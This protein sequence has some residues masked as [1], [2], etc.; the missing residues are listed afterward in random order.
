M[1]SLQ[2]AFTITE[3]ESILDR[4]TY[5]KAMRLVNAGAVMVENYEG[6]RLEGAVI[7][8]GKR[9]HPEVYMDE[10]DDIFTKCDCH[11]SAYGEICVH[12]AALLITWSV[13]T[14]LPT[15]S[16]V[17]AYQTFYKHKYPPSIINT[18]SLEE[19]ARDLQAY[20]SMLTVKELRAL[21]KERNVK[22]SGLKREVILDQLVSG[23]TEPG[24]LDLALQRLPFDSR[25][26]FSYVCILAESLNFNIHP[27]LVSSRFDALLAMHS[28]GQTVRTAALCLEDL[29]QAGLLFGNQHL[30]QV[31]LQVVA[32]PE[33]QP[34][35]FKSTQ[36]TGVQKKQTVPFSAARLGLFLLVL[37]RSEKLKCAPDVQRDNLGWPV[38]LGGRQT[39]G[40]L[41]VLSENV[42]FQKELLAD[43][44]SVAGCDENQVDLIARVL[45]TGK[46]WSERQ[47]EKL[48][49]YFLSWLQLSLADQSKQ[50]LL[51]AS[52]VETTME[53]SAARKAGHFVVQRSQHTYFKWTQF[54]AALSR[55][56]LHLIDLVGRAPGGAWF[57]IDYLLRT[58][59]VLFPDWFEENLPRNSRSRSAYSSP[60]ISIHVNGKLVDTSS[61]DTWANTYGR[62]HLEML[63]KTLHWLGLVDVAYQNDRPQAFRISA[64]GEYLL[65]RRSDYPAST[66]NKSSGL[67]YNSDG[68]LVLDVM[69]AQPELIRLV[70]N[71]AIPVRDKSAPA[72]KNLAQ[73]TFGITMK[74]LQ[75]EFRAGKQPETIIEVIERN[76]GKALPENISQGIQKLWD[77]FGKMHL[78]PDM[79]LIEFSDD[80]CLPEL[81]AGTRL[82][83]ILLHTFSPRLIAIHKDAEAEYLEELVAKGY[84]PRLEQDRH[85][86]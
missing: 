7:E 23:L 42:Y 68:L 27:R 20:L 52:I 79:T 64:F 8:N 78:Y 14:R 47:P 35:L 31:P 51:L 62:L 46:L 48:S 4:E 25:L 72:K 66:D 6:D 11:S 45:E 21:A 41:P 1:N 30:M 40:Q 26:V 18:H 69:K 76:A 12:L 10:D 29:R 34:A 86:K 71:I 15:D 22:V 59:H 73:L 36:G 84:T 28:S 61:Y 3:I 19:I 17:D 13:E 2:D 33:I 65:G 70:M 50:L 37:A 77:R 74:G 58:L 38:Q 67:S 39:S 32:H 56:R 82:N 49:N 53:L 85:E 60:P 55:V 44:A 80:Y 24:N 63:T 9:Y 43:I 5:S 57:E 75:N 54:T 83:Q 16:P 81:L